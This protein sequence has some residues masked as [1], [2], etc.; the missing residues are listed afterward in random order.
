MIQGL[1]RAD[2]VGQR[3]EKAVKDKP[4][5]VFD[6]PRC[7]ISVEQRIQAGPKFLKKYIHRNFGKRIGVDYIQKP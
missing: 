7:D 3:L 5:A 6:P 1:C 4:R 2:P